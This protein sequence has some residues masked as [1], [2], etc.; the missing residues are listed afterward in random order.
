MDDDRISVHPRVEA[1]RV[2][3]ATPV[4]SAITLQEGVTWV[5]LCV[6]AVGGVRPSLRALVVRGV[7]ADAVQP[8]REEGAAPELRQAEPGAQE[9]LLHGVGGVV[10]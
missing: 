4:I 6:L 10:G 3:S 2:P 9:R 5:R 7:D 8:G 1:T